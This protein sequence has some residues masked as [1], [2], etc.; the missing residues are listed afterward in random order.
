MQ[1]RGLSA[2][3]YR[4]VRARAGRRGRQTT[5]GLWVGLVLV[6]TLLLAA[7]CGGDGNPV[8]N[9]PSPSPASPT[10]AAEATIDPEREAVV[11]AYA[12]FI[13]VGNVA[14]NRG[15]SEYP[16][17]SEVSAGPALAETRNAIRSHAENGRVYSGNLVLAAAEVTTLNVDAPQG[18]PQAVIE[19]CIDITNYVLTYVDSGE[20]ADVERGLEMF[21]ATIDMYL[22]EGRWMVVAIESHRETPCE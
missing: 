17:L 10:P 12:R 19:A 8:E 14:A 15:E 16:E 22:I 13:E 18:E 20:P 21:M 5:G 1:T 9:T 11:A 7:G 2:G 4:L 6:T 3:T